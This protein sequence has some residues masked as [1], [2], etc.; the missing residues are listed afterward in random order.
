[1]I[2]KICFIICGIKF[3]GMERQALEIIRGLSEDSS[4]EITLI[5]FK[6]EESLKAKIPE[7]IKFLLIPR[8]SKLDFSTMITIST[9][10][11]ERSIELVYC[12]DT[13]AVLYSF[14]GVKN[15]K[16]PYIDGS[17]RDSGI[18]KGFEYLYRK[19][20][21]SLSYKIVANSRAGLKYYKIKAGEVVYN[22][23]DFNRFITAS[24]ENN[25]SIVMNANFSDYKDHKTFFTAIKIMLESGLLD[26]VYLIGAGKNLAYWQECVKRWKNSESVVFLG[27][28]NNVEEILSKC[29]IG[30]LCSTKKYREGVSNSLL[31]YM[32]AGLITIGSDIG[33][34]S[35]IIDHEK[36]GFLFEVENANDL[37][38]KLYHCLYKLNYD[39]KNEIISNARTT[40]KEKFDFATN[41]R[42]IKKII[43]EVLNE[44]RNKSQFK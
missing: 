19:I 6:V 4:L 37:A 42:K 26:V 2:K 30:V 39:D 5:T 22:S 13:L 12:F 29:K 8:K 3:G 17:I 28:I 36:N 11:E 23:I 27:H 44:K 15:N 21:L 25:K 9:V 18:N 1:M 16:I 10:L 7:N 41:N 43:E 31:E 33:G 32:G 34:T 24:D 14:Y 35:E 40:L 20:F 38:D